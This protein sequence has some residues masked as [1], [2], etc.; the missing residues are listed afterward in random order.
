MIEVEP[1]LVLPLLVFLLYSSWSF[2]RVESSMPASFIGK[3]RSPKRAF[4][5]PQE[6]PHCVGS[7]LNLKEP[8]YS[9]SPESKDGVLG[10]RLPKPP[11]P[12]YFSCHRVVPTRQ[13]RRSMH[14]HT[15]T[16]LARKLC[17]QAVEGIE[18][19]FAFHYK[20]LTSFWENGFN[21]TNWVIGN[22]NDGSS[23]D[24]F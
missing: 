2:S 9:T 20:I 3:V 12:H 23:C 15:V 5:L 17:A 10:K 22:L 13:Q 11:Q 1:L 6:E 21:F 8:I 19:A 18:A 14:R 16:W 7:H 4:Q 24:S